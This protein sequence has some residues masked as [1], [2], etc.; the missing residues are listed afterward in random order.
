[1]DCHPIIR[2][3]VA[4]DSIRKRPQPLTG[5]SSQRET[6]SVLHS[7]LGAEPKNSTGP[8]I[9]GHTVTSLLQHYSAPNICSFKPEPL[10]PSF[11]S[12]G[13]TQ[14]AVWG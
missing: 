4:T 6:I 2:D 10:S 7:A 1:M 12:S 13:F 5:A 14:I 11:H 8:M 3:W 9:C